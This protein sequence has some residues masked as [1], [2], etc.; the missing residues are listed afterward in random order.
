M[1]IRSVV[2]VPLAVAAIVG[3]VAVA[4][5][6]AGAAST[7][8]GQIPMASPPKDTSKENIARIAAGTEASVP[9]RPAWMARR[10]WS[11]RWPRPVPSPCSPR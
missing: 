8:A 3:V 10:V 5:P 11:A 2:L 9:T 4:G 7:T 1:K 6:N